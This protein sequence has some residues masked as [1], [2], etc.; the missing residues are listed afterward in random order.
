MNVDVLFGNG[1]WLRGLS[2]PQQVVDYL[3]LGAA[4]FDAGTINQLRMVTTGSDPRV[5]TNWHVRVPGGT[6]PQGTI[7]L[8]QYM[9]GSANGGNPVPVPIPGNPN[10]GG[11][12]GLIPDF[13]GD[14][15]YRLIFETEPGRV[16]TGATYPG[17]SR[18]N[19]GPCIPVQFGTIEEAVDYARSHGEE[20]LIVPDVETAWGIVEGTI[21]KPSAGISPAVMGL[22]ALAVIALLLWR[23]K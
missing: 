13:S 15:I 10:V 16:D 11:S 9:T 22:G 8:I 18:D 23:K 3:N 17:C 20:P 19:T 6:G 7:P 2:A 4:L 21:P 1:D 12:D 5:A 14:P